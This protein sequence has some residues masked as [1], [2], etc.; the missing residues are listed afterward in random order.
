MEY[1]ACINLTTLCLQSG[2]FGKAEAAAHKAISIDPFHYMGYYNLFA[3]LNHNIDN[4]NI[5]NPELI[6]K[7]LSCI[8]N[9]IGTKEQ[10]KKMLNKSIAY[11]EDNSSAYLS[12]AQ[13]SESSG[14]KVL[15]K[16]DY[17]AAIFHHP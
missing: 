7:A 2:Q 15:A 9:H 14:K 1:G 10:D 12:R 11:C 16:N 13:F 8:Y 6:L 4:E 17:E 5:R 3:L